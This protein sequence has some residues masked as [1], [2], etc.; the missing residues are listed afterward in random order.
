LREHAQLTVFK[1]R[2]AKIGIRNKN[3]ARIA[4]SKLPDVEA[5]F[6]KVFDRK[7]AVSLHILATPEAKTTVFSHPPS[8][9]ASPAPIET[10]SPSDESN[11]ILY[12]RFESPTQ[13]PGTAIVQEKSLKIWGQPSKFVGTPYVQAYKGPLPKGARGIEF[14]TNVAPDASTT[15]R[16]NIARWSGTRVGVNTQGNRVCLK[17]LTIE[18]HQPFP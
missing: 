16:D 8:R 10:P 7:V 18:N 9:Q 12:H 2:E 6:Q 11:L 1:G 13:T 4:Q 14:R 15:T 3:L 5:A 17:I